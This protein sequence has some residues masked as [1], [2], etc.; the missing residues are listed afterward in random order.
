MPEGFTGAGRGSCREALR[1]LLCCI[2]WLYEKPHNR[3][4]G[5]PSAHDDAGAHFRQR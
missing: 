4:H 2:I 3:L 5:W 1:Y